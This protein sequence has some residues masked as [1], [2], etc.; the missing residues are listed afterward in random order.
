M[1]EWL[2]REGGGWAIQT[3]F[4]KNSPGPKDRG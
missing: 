3:G 4:H 2:K 1:S